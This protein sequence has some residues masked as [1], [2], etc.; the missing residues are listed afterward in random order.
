VISLNQKG[1]EGAG[2]RLL[3]EAILA[4]FI[5]VIILG[6]ISQ[7]DEWRWKVSERRLFDGF[8]KSLNSPDGSVVFEKDLILRDGSAYSRSAFASSV[9]GIDKDCVELN[10]SS[11][12]AFTSYQGELVEINTVIKTDIYYK[13]L[14][15]SLVGWDDC[16]DYCYVSFG[17]DFEE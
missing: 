12:S 13:C 9:T 11:S 4:V 2:F 15:G 1:Q 10:A 14:P 8:S 3:I 6:V 17:Q 5:L 16:P 7:L